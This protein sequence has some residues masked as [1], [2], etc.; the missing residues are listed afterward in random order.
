MLPVQW[1]E[2]RVNQLLIFRRIQKYNG[3]AMGFLHGVYE[4]TDML[5]LLEVILLLVFVVL[6]ANA[7]ITSKPDHKDKA[8]PSDI[9][10]L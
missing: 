1:E 2:S 8:L 5:R 4:A 10:S 9:K 3:L 7:F 6:L